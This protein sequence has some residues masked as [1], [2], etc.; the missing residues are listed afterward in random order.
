MEN[1]AELVSDEEIVA[2]VVKR[3]FWEPPM[4]QRLQAMLFLAANDV[5]EE[6]LPHFD[7]FEAFIEWVDEDLSAEWINGTVEIMSPASIPH[8]MAV[9]FLVQLLGLFVR[10]RGLGMVLAAPLKMKLEQYGPEPD[11]VFVSEAH[12]ERW[13]ETYLD[14]PADV[15]VEVVSP[16]STERDRGRK[17]VA[18]EQARIPE[19]W[20]FDPLRKEAHFYRLGDDARYH[21]ILPQDGRYTSPLLPGFWLKATW[22]W[23]TPLPSPIRLLREMAVI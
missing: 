2:E 16:E 14:G 15:V 7:T 19:Y 6:G 4:R 22:L 11:L 20:L 3:R 21:A 13:K 5:E 23:E 10:E 1:L 18:Y 9:T 8:Q 12:E 17:Y